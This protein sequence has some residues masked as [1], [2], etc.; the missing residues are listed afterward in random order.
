MRLRTSAAGFD[1]RKTP[2][3]SG[4]F[5]AGETPVPISNTV[6]KPCWADCTA[7]ESV[8][9]SRTSPELNKGQLPYGSWPFP[10]SVG[11]CNCPRSVLFDSFRGAS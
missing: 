7:R 5:S 1:A 2:Q 11:K 10:F 6:V 9:E 3:V 8:W 4:D